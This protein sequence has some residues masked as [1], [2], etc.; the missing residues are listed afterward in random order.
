MVGEVQVLA[1]RQYWNQYVQR[2]KVCP[3]TG[4]PQEAAADL[5]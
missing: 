5:A 4:T 1:T 2:F 3:V